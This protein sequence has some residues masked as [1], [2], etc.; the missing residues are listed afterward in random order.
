MRRIL[1]YIAVAFIFSIGI[2]LVAYYY[3]PGY[4]LFS[5]NDL[6]VETSLLF[7]LA[8]LAISFILF[9]TL[10]RFLS[11]S[12]KLPSWLGL[13]YSHNQ[14]E[15][16]RNAL[17]K[18]LIEM[19]E[20]RF[21]LAEKILLKQARH[22]KT[23]LLNYLI[24]ARTAQ[25]QGAYDRRD[26]YLRLAHETMPSAD[27]AIGITQ[28]ELQIAQKQ[29]EQA[30]ATLNHLSSIAP[31]HTYVKKLQARV[32]EHLADWD[33]LKQLLPALKKS[34]ML[35]TEKYE[36][37]EKTTWFELLKQ[38]IRNQQ[39]VA[40]IDLWSHMPRSLRDN[41]DMLKAYVQYLMETEHASE[42]EG[43][44]RQH[45][46][47][48]W[49]NDFVKLYA[50]LNTSNPKKLLETAE[51]W[52][53]QQQRNPVLLLSLG[54]LCIKNELWGKARTYFETSLSIKA[55][56][57]ACY[58]LATLLENR[59]EDPKLAQ[60]YYKQGLALCVEENAKVSNQPASLPELVRFDDTAPLLKIIQ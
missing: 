34:Q 57:D 55:L 44:I 31:K 11:I 41:N 8:T 25:Q 42:A 18:G 5:F 4:V 9:Y 46:S 51:T 15:K 58:Q 12:L 20:G 39:H 32:Y 1:F 38:V 27:I 29:F 21:D 53:H 7:A 13:Q 16:A 48:H 56:P 47:H 19:A 54:K 26:E 14:A 6:T 28:A 23:G 45:L 24:A 37:L 49:S 2:G 50:D 10:L 52:L 30:L 17:I 40:I 3:G 60:D 59:M 36:Q 35:D 33:S 22:S 43:L